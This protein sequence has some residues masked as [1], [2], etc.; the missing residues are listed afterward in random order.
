MFNIEW[1][2]NMQGAGRNFSGDNNVLVVGA[3]VT[4]AYTF[5]KTH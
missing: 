4:W 2:E 1:V 5:I 3:L